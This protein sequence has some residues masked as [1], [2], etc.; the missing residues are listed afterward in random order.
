M[1]LVILRESN[2]T[3]SRRHAARIVPMVTST[4]KRFLR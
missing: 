2:T 3:A 4:P 1:E